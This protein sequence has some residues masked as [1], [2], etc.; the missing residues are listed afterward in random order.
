[1]VKELQRLS[2]EQLVARR[3]SVDVDAQPAAAVDKALSRS[4]SARAPSGDGIVMRQPYAPS[5]YCGMRRPST[6]RPDESSHRTRPDDGVTHEVVVMDQVIQVMG[7]LLILSAFA[8]AQR[9]ALSQRSRMYL[10]LN[11]VGS[12]VLAVLA[13]YETQFG[14][15]LLEAC[16]AVVSGWS[17]VQQLRGHYDVAGS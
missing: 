12:A 4:T 2:L 7:S 16:W 3:V 14:F 9:G 17:L 6:G 15:L 10:V 8:A 13:A 1:V 11:L 5:R